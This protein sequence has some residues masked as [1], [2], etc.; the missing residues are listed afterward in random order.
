MNGQI[1]G[2]AVLVGSQRTRSGSTTICCAISASI[3]AR[4][5]PRGRRHSGVEQ[6]GGN[7]GQPCRGNQRAGARVMIFSRSASLRTLGRLA[8]PMVSLSRV[9]LSA[10]IDGGERTLTGIAMAL[11]AMVLFSGMDGISKFLAV[12]YHPLEIAAMRH[13]FTTLALLPFVIRSPLALRA[14]RPLLQIGRGLCMY[15]SSI[16]FIVGLSHLPIADA[17]AIGFVSP[18]LVTALSIPFLGEKV[19]IRRWSAVIVGFAGG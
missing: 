2:K 7:T 14:R 6:S 12:D 10:P 1:Y 15:A 13:V 19:G 3:A 17:S 8:S 9:A 5:K 18:L 16:L 4:Q 11:A